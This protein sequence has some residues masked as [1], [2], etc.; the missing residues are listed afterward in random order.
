MV[1]YAVMTTIDSATMAWILTLTAGAGLV[2]SYVARTT[3]GRMA[4]L[5]AAA[6]MLLTLTAGLTYEARRSS[7]AASADVLSQALPDTTSHTSSST[8]SP[9]PASPPDPLAPYVSSDRCAACHPGHYAS[10]HASYHRKMTQVASPESVLGPFDGRT[11]EAKGRSYRLQRRGDEYWVEM[12]DPDWEA[13]LLASRV[14]PETVPDAS[15]PRR[16]KRI[17]MTTGSHH[18]QT[19][20]VASDRDRRLFNFPWLWLNEDQRW[21]PRE[22][23]FIRPPDGPRTYDVWHDSC[24]ECHAVAGEK[25]HD[26]RKGWEPSAAELGIACEACHGPGKEHIR[27]HRSPLGRYLSRADDEPDPTIV[28]PAHLDAK[29][30]SQV[31]GYCHGI[32]M[33]KQGPLRAGVRFHPGDD[34]RETRVI[35]RASDRAAA[36]TDPIDQRDWQLLQRQL[37]Q[38]KATNPTVLEERF[39]PD[40]MVRVSGREHNGMIESACYESGE[41]SCLSCH[42][43]HDSDPDDQ[44]ARNQIGDAAC[45]QCHPIYAEDPRAHTRHAPDSA[46]SRCQNCHMPH[47]VYGLLSSIRSHWI[48]S[49]SAATHQETGRTNAC[50]LCHLDRSLGWAADRLEAWYGQPRPTLTTDEEAIGEG[51]RQTL[52]GNAH[53]RAMMAWHMGWPEA[54]A[55]SGD[56]WKGFFLGHLLDDPYPAVRY[57]AGDSLSRLPLGES[58]SLAEYDFLDESA[59]RGE[60]RDEAM[61]VWRDAVEDP[62]RRG[63]DRVARLLDAKGRL[64]E[65]VFQRLAKTRDDQVMDLRE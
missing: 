8:R 3:L 1:P 60:A 18:M 48:D 38:V 62:D 43:M 2:V 26:P 30:A 61:A 52:T 12:A 51:I 37:D 41:L 42:S 17:V 11:L 10:W 7:R 64:D 25:N 21:I 28:N 45:L 6:L 16:W 31:C 57:L 59:E 40:G 9:T 19:Y 32:N 46:G 44:L 54:T 27:A 50:N 65:V 4:W 34:L 20:W 23:G 55:A 29:A 33:W 56:A 47:T 63:I 35:M 14:S 5:L 53:Q 13:D 36:S 39:W 24:I 58:G 49:P 22:D 15:A